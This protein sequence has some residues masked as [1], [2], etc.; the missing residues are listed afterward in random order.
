MS[1]ILHIDTSTTVCSVAVSEN[2]A[3]IYHKE[4]YDGPSHSSLLGGMVSDA[5]SFTD[6]HGIPFDAVSISNGPGSY[7]GLRIGLSMA[8]GLCYGRDLKLLNI[9][10]LK[11]LCVPLLL[12]NYDMADDALLCPMIDARRKEVYTALYTRS[13]TSV[14]DVQSKIIDESSF[15]E[16]LDHPIYFFGNGSTKCKELISH[17]NAHFVDNIHPL[18][19]NMMPLAEM[20]F[21]HGEF[22]DVGYLEP[23]YLKEFMAG[24]KSRRIVES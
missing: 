4:E 9:P 3:I 5:L 8:K 21:L 14:E 22:A 10:T 13:L 2:G 16:H 11:V 24:P 20:A 15:H 6:N 18:A 12:G 1:C 23:M 17:P 19:K 7:T